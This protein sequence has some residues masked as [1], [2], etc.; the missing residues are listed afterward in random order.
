MTAESVVQAMLNPAVPPE[1]AA[2]DYNALPENLRRQVDAVI[3]VKKA[4]SQPRLDPWIGPGPGWR[5]LDIVAGP[6]G[7]TK[8]VPARAVV[9]TADTTWDD[10]DESI[11]AKVLKATLA[12]SKKV[13]KRTKAERHARRERKLRKAT[14]RQAKLTKKISTLPAGPERQV[15]GQKLAKV[16]GTVTK[17]RRKLGA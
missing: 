15:L 14:K 9:K 5:G 17:L 12:G 1:E 7:L 2:A 16:N 3:A 8:A 13:R 10:A 4:L 11:G 6:G